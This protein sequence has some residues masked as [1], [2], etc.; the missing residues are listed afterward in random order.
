MAFAWNNCTCEGAHGLIEHITSKG[1]H[2]SVEA[3]HILD[4]L[5]YRWWRAH[6]TRSCFMISSKSYGQNFYLPFTKVFFFANVKFCQKKT[7][8]GSDDHQ[9]GLKVSNLN[10][11]YHLANPN[12]VTTPSSTNF[13]WLTWVK[14]IGLLDYN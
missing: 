8:V 14:I 13:W 6:P 9:Q 10:L 4:L 11:H 7:L 12:V 1:S 3:T 2:E 5:S